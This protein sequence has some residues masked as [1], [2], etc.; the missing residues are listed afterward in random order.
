MGMTLMKLSA[1][2]GY[3]YLTKQVARDDL[4]KTNGQ[5]LADYYSEKGERPGVW[6]G[7]GLA[8]LGESNGLN[9]GDVVS[10][11]QMKNLFGMGVHPNAEQVMND[12]ARTSTNPED[13]E[14]AALLGTPFTDPNENPTPFVIETSRAFNRWLKANG[15]SRAEDV[16]EEVRAQ[17]RTDV[18][19]EQFVAAH[20]RAPADERE[21]AEFVTTST[22]QKPASIAGFDLTFSAPKSFTILWAAAT[23]EQREQL[24]KVHDDAVADTLKWVEDNA[25]F[26]RTGKGGLRQVKTRG[27]MATAFIHRD[28]RDGDPHL[29]THVAISSKVQLDTNDPSNA[30]DRLDPDRWLAL[31]GQAIYKSTVS[32]SEHY[33][34][35]LEAKSRSLGLAFD[36][37]A[38][39]GRDGKQIVREVAGISPELI[40]A[41]SSRCTEIEAAMATK[42]AEFAKEYGR[43]PSVKE[44]Y[45]IRRAAHAETRKDKAEPRSLDDQ[46]AEWTPRID[47][48]LKATR[49]RVPG[50]SAGLFDAAREASRLV[51]EHTERTPRPTTPEAVDDLARQIVARVSAKRAV[52]DLV[53][54]RAEAERSVRRFGMNEEDETRLVHDLVQAATSSAISTRIDAIDP[55]QEPE[56]MRRADGTSVYRR[57]FSEKF[58][59]RETLDAE[60]SLLAAAKAEGGRVLAPEAVDMALLEQTANG[61]MLNDGQAHLVREMTTSGRMVQLALAPAGTG[62]TTAMSVLTK[63]WTDSGGTVIGLAPSAAAAKVLGSSIDTSADTLDKLVWHI[64]G[65]Q[66]TP[67]A[68]MN[69]IGADTMVIIDEAGMAGTRNLATAVEYLTRRG[70]QVRLIGDD[71]QLASPAAGGALKNIQSDVGALTLSEVVRFTTPGEAEASLAVRS[72]KPEA[73][74]FYLDTGRVSVGNETALADQVFTA[75]QDANAAGREALMMAH[76]NDVVTDLNARARA[77]RLATSSAPLGHEVALRSGLLASTGDTI[78]TRR[79][80]RRLTLNAND[81]VKNGDRWTITETRKDGSLRVQHTT[82]AHLVTLPAD[83]VREH[84][85]LGYASTFHGAQGQTV[86]EGLALLGGHEDRQLFYVGTTRGRHTNRVFVPVGGDGDEHNSIN[87]EALIPSTAVETLETIITRDGSAVSASTTLR[88][89]HDPSRLL[90]QSVARYDDA[91]A[92]ATSHILGQEAMHDIARLAETLAPGVTSA[93][94]WDTLHARLAYLA[95]DDVDVAAA[96]RAAIEQAP[97]EGARDAAAVIDWRL[98]AAPSPASHDG[99]LPWVPGI[100][101]RVAADQTYGPWVLARRDLVTRDAHALR[102]QTLAQTPNSAPEWSRAFLDAPRLHTEVATWRAATAVPEDSPDLFGKPRLSVRQRDYQRALNERAERHAPSITNP[103][104]QFVALL[105]QAAPRVLADQ[106]WPTLARRLDAAHA[107]GRDIETV[108]S[109]VL[110]E[111]ANP[112]PIEH[113]AA[114]LWSRVLPHLGAVT[115]ATETGATGRLRPAWTATLEDTLGK[116]LAGWVV[117]DPAWASLVATVTEQATLAGLSAEQVITHAVEGIETD[118]LPQPGAD[119]EPGRLGVHELATVLLWRVTET[120]TP[121]HNAHD[122]LVDERD[123]RDADVEDFL[124]LLAA[125]HD[126]QPSPDAHEL[127]ADVAADLAAE[128]AQAASENARRD[129]N[130]WA[131]TFTTSEE[132]VLQLTQ[133]AHDYYRRAYEDSPAARYVTGRFGSD[134]RDTP[135]EIGYAAP[136]WSGLVDHLR[137]TQ[138]ATNVELVDAGLAKYNRGGTGVY[139]FFRNRAMLPI[140]NPQRQVIG[141]HARALDD[142]PAKYINSPDTPIFRKGQALYGANEGYLHA[143][144]L[145]AQ[146]K[147]GVVR[148]EGPFDAIAVTLASSGH[149]IGV[150]TGGTAFTTRQAERVAGLARDGQVHLALDNDRAGRRAT[151][152]AYWKLIEAGVQPRSVT[153]PGAKDPGELYENSPDM[154]AMVLTTPEL[155]PSSAV[156]VAHI[157]AR[158]ILSNGAPTIEERVIAARTIAPAIAALP[159]EEWDAV[160]TQAAPALARDGEDEHAVD[161]LWREVIAVEI[162]WP[163]AT[164]AAAAA[165]ADVA[166]AEER[167]DALTRRLGPNALRANDSRR[168]LAESRHLLRQKIEQEHAKSST[169]SRTTSTSTPTPREGEQTL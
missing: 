148:V 15:L 98:D 9:A 7:S 25:T 66:G 103:G 12:A 151:V 112:L 92:H 8:G 11:D 27:L 104:E 169:P 39:S 150:T 57:A 37:R 10:E 154:L 128:N 72:G 56:D 74:G 44:T 101:A 139:D 78:V 53:H 117:S 52:F 33:N 82:S 55:V 91:L 149:M 153:I 63:A 19:R 67:P 35:M 80:N 6:M 76:A 127:P 49:T 77:H 46:L 42:T 141:F 73:L 106:W 152:D 59:T 94:A 129:D 132:R 134:L 137:A 130:Q 30:D 96:L 79:N 100:P 20:D 121:L 75:W 126:T 144:S 143:K 162:Q 51:R 85:D 29:H 21:L 31:D 119:H 147:P 111:S 102:D 113:A 135:Y 17:I 4:T 123:V 109:D 125:E 34:R 16:P 32:A 2:S 99:P 158:Q 90:A 110:D 97:L 24:Q 107:A 146:R 131:P 50:G 93:P 69:T 3:T 60:A 48:A 84:V 118:A 124:A 18:A 142:S 138:G 116:E 70:A 1:G 23:P 145:G 36:V 45:D 28:S 157:L 155:Q 163:T 114:A 58:T 47:A 54:V 159:V 115:A 89:E 95:L 133:A 26:T 167:L 88:D 140:H 64:R 5:A 164:D 86:D 166:R 87:P 168:M 156:D 71:Q 65:G 61:V 83:Y 22:R 40:A 62:K 13:V 41:M 160:I 120:T 43:P 14:R 122:D 81:F 38:G 68:W 105:E 161:L 165:P 136:G 108:L